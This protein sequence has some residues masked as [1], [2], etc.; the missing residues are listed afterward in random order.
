[1][2]FSEPA[3]SDIKSVWNQSGIRTYSSSKISHTELRKKKLSFWYNLKTNCVKKCRCSYMFCLICW[4]SVIVLIMLL[5]II[6][7]VNMPHTSTNDDQE[8]PS[9]CQDSNLDSSVVGEMVVSDLIRGCCGQNCFNNNYPFN[10]QPL[11]KCI[12]KTKIKFRLFRSDSDDTEVLLL[13][14]LK[15]VPKQLVPEDETILIIH[16]Y[17]SKAT[18]EWIVNLTRAL[19]DAQPQSNIIVVDWQYY[20]RDNVY[21][22]AAANTRSVAAF[23]SQFIDQLVRKNAVDYTRLW[24]IGH[25]LGAH[26]CG[27]I[28]IKTLDRIHRITGLDPAGL[29]FECKSSVKIGL[30]KDCADVVEVIHT[31][32]DGKSSY[33]TKRPLGHVDYY[34]NGIAKPPGCNTSHRQK[35]KR[36]RRQQE[37]DSNN[38]HTSFD[39]SNNKTMITVDAACSGGSY[40]LF[41]EA[42]SSP[43]SCTAPYRCEEQDL[44]SMPEK[45]R[46]D[47]EGGVCATIGYE[48]PRSQGIFY[49]E[50]NVNSPYCSKG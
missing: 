35:R 2:E 9:F 33:G 6:H 24:C 34:V 36:K 30:N 48:V 20:A 13:D 14:H 38:T 47:C 28:G 25:S 45:C 4:T 5:I 42:I 46:H 29:C 40:Q 21:A 32:A 27:H 8:C 3:M 44:A 1:M 41:T 16:G 17:M 43:T 12:D 31:D 7:R 10:E 22:Q 26:L 18:S 15:P 50:A 37:S 39:P 19:F 11:P 23:T 49:L